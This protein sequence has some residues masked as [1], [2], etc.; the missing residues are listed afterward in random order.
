M[1]K[2]M[3]EIFIRLGISSTRQLD[4]ARK[5]YVAHN[6]GVPAPAPK[7]RQR[8]PNAGGHYTF[9]AEQA[10]RPKGASPNP[11]LLSKL[12]FGVEVVAPKQVGSH[13]PHRVNTM[14]KL[15]H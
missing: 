1:D 12:M 8:T 9:A 3:A 14:M 10:S 13:T 15:F 6:R 4:R 11:N 7:E 5:I 2:M